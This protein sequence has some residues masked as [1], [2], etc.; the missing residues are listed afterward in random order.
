MKR[1]YVRTGQTI[2]PSKSGRG[3][4]TIPTYYT[5][6][7]QKGKYSMSDLR[8]IRARN[9]VGRPPKNKDKD[10]PPLPEEQKPEVKA[11]EVLKKKDGGVTIGVPTAHLEVKQSN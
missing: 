7:K 2:V 10:A 8:E 6:E 4:R 1:E 3:T 11:G 9:G 5:P